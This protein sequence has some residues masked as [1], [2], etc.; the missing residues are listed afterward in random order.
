MF[1]KTTYYRRFERYA[2]IHFINCVFLNIVSNLYINFLPDTFSNTF[3]KFIIIASSCFLVLIAETKIG[4]SFNE[5]STSRET[6][7]KAML[8]LRQHFMLIL[9]CRWMSIYYMFKKF[10]CCWSQWDWT[11]A[12]YALSVPVLVNWF[13]TGSS[14]VV[15]NL[16]LVQLFWKQN[17]QISWNLCSVPW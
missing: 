5:L 14:Q 17:K 11:V 1:T 9:E 12:S 8:M 6:F 2:E 3:E 4:N 7:T 16:T 10:T 15:W 13:D